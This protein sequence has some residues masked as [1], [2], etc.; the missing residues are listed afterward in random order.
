MTN[1]DDMRPSVTAKPSAVL[2]YLERLAAGRAIVV[3]V[4]SNGGATLW[5]K[6][7]TVAAR[8]GHNA[9]LANVKSVIYDSTGA[10]LGYHRRLSLAENVRSMKGVVSYIILAPLLFKK[11]VAN[12]LFAP[13]Y[14]PIWWLCFALVALPSAVRA[15]YFDPQVRPCSSGDQPTG[16]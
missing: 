3:H 4:F 1:T 2:K 7:L 12:W 5:S 10:V 16:R 8:E 11:R 6:F 14:Y 9:L 15:L 13:L